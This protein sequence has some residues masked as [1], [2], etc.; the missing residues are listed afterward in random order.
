MTNTYHIFTHNTDE[1]TT[2]LTEATTIFN[3]FVA[4]YGCARLYKETRDTDGELLDE[5]CLE[6]VGEYPQ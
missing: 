5:T 3:Q 2:N 4:E 6:S 1:Y